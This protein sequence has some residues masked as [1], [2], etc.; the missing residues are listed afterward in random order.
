MGHP[1]QH[2]PDHQ[3]ISPEAY[4]V[5]EEK[6]DI[7]HEY[8]HG[9]LFAMTGASHHHNLIAVN[10]AAHLHGMLRDRGCFVYAMDMKIQVDA[11]QHYTYPDLSIVCGNI[12]FA[13]GRD[14]TI[15]NPVV[16]AEILSESTRDYDRGSKFTAYRN[17]ASLKDYL[18]IDQYRYHVEHFYKAEDHWVLAEY[19]DL[20]GTVIL[21]SVAAE[22]PLRTIYDRVRIESP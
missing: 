9:E 11:G 17:I 15:T 7:R 13:E 16:L 10:T 4:F 18:L 20:S 5:R 22:L 12:E 1:D 14:D 3:W 21:Q 8:H 2:Q 6:S 19:K